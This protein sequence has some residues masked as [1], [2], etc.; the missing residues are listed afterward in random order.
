L[1]KEERTLTKTETIKAF[2]AALEARDFEKAASYLSDDFVLSGPASQPL[3]KQEFIA[4]Q[5]A[6]ENAFEDWSFNSHDEVEQGD[7]AIAAVQITGTHTRDLVLP[8]PGIPPIPATYKKVSL[9]EEHLEFTFKGDKIVS[10][11]S[12]NVPG[13][14]IPGV[15]QQIGIQ[16]PPM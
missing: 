13:G 16:L 7:K 3:G 2:S 1:Q 5:S 11:T 14:G 12:D 8:M 15:L 10:L 4:V 6:F 9:P